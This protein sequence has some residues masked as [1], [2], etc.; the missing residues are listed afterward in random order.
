M[1]DATH[2]VS[3]SMTM[4]GKP[5]GFRSLVGYSATVWQQDYAEIELRLGPQHTNS[6]GILHGGVTMTIMDAAM[7]HAATWCSV[8]GHVRICVTIAMSTNFIAPAKTGLIRA[9]A[10]LHAI[11]D[12]VGSATAEVLDESGCLIA[13][14][15]ASFRYSRGSESYEGVAK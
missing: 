8:K 6:L 3:G 13:A 2:N 15:Q 14:A 10:R 4:S 12:R 9:T 1:T 5:S 11:H 7:G